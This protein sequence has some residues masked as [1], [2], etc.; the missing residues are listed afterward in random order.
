MYTTAY[1]ISVATAA[2]LGEPA[3]ASPSEPPTVWAY[4]LAYTADVTAVAEGGSD[5]TARF[6]DNL[7]LDVDGD[8]FPVMGWRGA[9]LHLTILANSGGQP[10]DAAGTLQGVNNI[11]VDHQTVRLYEL[12]V[13]QSFAGGNASLLAGLYDLNSE[14]YA[15]EAS[16]LLISPPFGIG[17]ELAATGPNGPSIFPST[18]LALRL[19]AGGEAGAYAQAAVVNARAGTL[20]DRDGVET[21]LDEGALMIAET[22][23]SGG[24]LRLAA[25]A[26][27][28]DREQPDIREILPSGDPAHS[29]AH[30]GYLLAEADVF[31]DDEG[32]RS[33][34]FARAGVSDGDTTD[35]EG[36]WQAGVRIDRPIAS[37][38]YSAFSAGVHRGVLSPKAR[39]N[40]RDA[41]IEAAGSEEGLEIT[42]SDRVGPI[43]IQPDLQIIR[44]PGGDRKA[45]P[46]IVATLRLSVA[47]P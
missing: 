41:G 16:D 30:G 12:W 31:G 42:W 23:W 22:G 26:W 32:S 3:P 13:E 17:S 19:R 43:T 9:R 8:L 20:G 21:G 35:F 38:P 40:L 6:L 47:L 24:P 2:L 39:A 37:R 28:Y 5:R 11:E 1:L 14:F 44:S 4:E 25:G 33:R 15:T 45:D 34:I 7:Q 18:A 27:R 10:N 36:G 29:R 46:V